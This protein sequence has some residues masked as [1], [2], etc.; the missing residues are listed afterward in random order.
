MEIICPTAHIVHDSEIFSSQARLRSLDIHV[1]QR[2]SDS[3]QLRSNL[4]HLH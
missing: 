3:N 1:V 2:T 4:D